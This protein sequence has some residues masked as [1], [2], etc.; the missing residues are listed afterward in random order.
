MI[1]LIFEAQVRQPNDNKLMEN[2]EEKKYSEFKKR[3][4]PSPNLTIRAYKVNRKL[5]DEV[6]SLLVS[7]RSLN[8]KKLT[9]KSE[10]SENSSSSVVALEE[11]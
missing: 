5:H 9:L 3:C 2:F 10:F 1:R 8:L 6:L 11:F 7:T 4:L